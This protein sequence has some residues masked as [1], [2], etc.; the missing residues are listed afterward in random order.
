MLRLMPLIAQCGFHASV[1]SLN[2]LLGNIENL[3]VVKL[4]PKTLTIPTKK[5]V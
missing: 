3:K 2:K 4:D 5:T 1:S